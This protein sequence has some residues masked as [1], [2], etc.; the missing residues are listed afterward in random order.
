MHRP[1]DG[2]QDLPRIVAVGQPHE[3]DEQGPGAVGG[4]RAPVVLGVL[5][6]QLE[7][8]GGVDDPPAPVA[9]GAGEISS[10]LFELE[11]PFS[12]RW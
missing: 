4:W 1:I 2:S 11:V 9:S 10:E 3:P 7:E 5:A 12:R 6:D 8:A